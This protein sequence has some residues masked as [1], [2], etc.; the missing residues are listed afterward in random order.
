MLKSPIL[1]FSEMSEFVSEGCR[2]KQQR[3]LSLPNVAIHLPNLATHLP[4]LATQLPI[5]ATNL[6]KVATNLP[7]F[8][9]LRPN[10]VTHLLRVTERK[11]LEEM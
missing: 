3:K 8:V 7:Y 10:L 5:E 4:N 11:S 6:H 2:S 9:T 1:Y